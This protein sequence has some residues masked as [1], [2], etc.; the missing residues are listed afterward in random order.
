MYIAKY[1]KIFKII[2][3]LLV[4]LGVCRFLAFFFWQ[5]ISRL[6]LNNTK[7]TYLRKVVLHNFFNVYWTFDFNVH[8]SFVILCSI[9]PHKIK[10]ALNEQMLPDCEWRTSFI[11]QVCS[12]WLNSKLCKCQMCNTNTS[13]P[14]GDKQMSCSPQQTG[15]LDFISLS[16]IFITFIDIMLLKSVWLPEF[17]IKYFYLHQLNSLFYEFKEIYF[18]FQRKRTRFMG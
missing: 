1:C 4:Y 16:F 14:A 6:K 9:I 5:R 15:N 12:V 10:L 18:H 7:N 17:L 8:L 2:G 11:S 13:L 3:L